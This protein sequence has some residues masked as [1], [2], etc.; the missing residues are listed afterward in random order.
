M[1]FSGPRVKYLRLGGQEQE[2][3]VR[4]QD[5]KLNGKEELNCL[6]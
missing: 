4:M 2:G 6:G 1:K 3:E 5:Q